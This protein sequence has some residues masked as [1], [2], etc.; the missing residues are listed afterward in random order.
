MSGSGSTIFIG[1]YADGLRVR[2]RIWCFWLTIKSRLVQYVIPF[3]LL[4]P[5]PH[6]L[7][8]IFKKNMV[9]TVVVLGAG[10]AGL[11]LAHKL[12]K[13][14]VPKVRDKL[15]VVLV[16]PNTHF[17]VSGRDD[18]QPFNAREMLLTIISGTLLQ[19]AASF[20]APLQT[21]SYSFQ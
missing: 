15:K 4:P 21:N 11:P 12:L 19:S 17:F 20:Q 5:G 2:V 10:W 1:R 8:K 6:S 3:P 18:S 14:T 16:S 9:K 7:R 13:Y